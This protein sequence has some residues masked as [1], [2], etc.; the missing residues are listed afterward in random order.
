MLTQTLFGLLRWKHGFK[1]ANG[2]TNLWLVWCVVEKRSAEEPAALLKDV[3]GKVAVL[4]STV[5]RSAEGGFKRETIYQI[6][7]SPHDNARSGF[8]G[9]L[10]HEVATVETKI[11]RILTK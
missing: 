4:V 2:F 11:L 7:F 5:S 3:D 1:F 6:E 10:N 8:S 9:F